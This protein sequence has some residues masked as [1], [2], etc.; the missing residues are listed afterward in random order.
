MILQSLV[1]IQMMLKKWSF[2][3]FP[4]P[5]L[6]LKYCQNPPKRSQKLKVMGKQKSPISFQI[7]KPNQ[8]CRTPPP[9]L[10]PKFISWSKKH[11]MWHDFRFLLLLDNFQYNFRYLV[12]IIN[13]FY[14]SIDKS[15]NFVQKYICKSRV[16]TSFITSIL[17]PFS[18]SS[19]EILINSNSSSEWVIK[20][21]NT[22]M[23]KG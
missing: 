22:S 19:W 7:H 17:S 11:F 15:H 18:M 16:S 5:I 3:I 4:Q 13:N 6:S 23:V 12:V 10:R 20:T 9:Q 2:P 1:L 21:I 8:C 14:R